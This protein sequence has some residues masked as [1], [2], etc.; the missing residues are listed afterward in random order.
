[1]KINVISDLHGESLYREYKDRDTLYARFRTGFDFSKLEKC[2]ILVIA[3]DFG[4]IEKDF[5]A[6]MQ[7]A[8]K[9]K[10]RIYKELVYVKGNHDFYSDVPQKDSVFLDNNLNVLSNSWNTVKKINNV[11]FVCTPLWSEILDERDTCYYCMNDYVY[12]PKFNID[13]NNDLFY[14]NVEFLKN[15]INLIE[16]RD[17]GDIVIVTHHVPHKKLIDKHFINS[18]LNEAFTV[19]HKNTK[20]S[21]IIKNKKNRIKLWIH[22]HT[23]SFLIKEMNGITFVRNPIGYTRQYGNECDFK[24]DCVFEI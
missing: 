8:L 7:E 12:I 13:T 17:D 4:Y 15:T 24:Y 1:M 5:E 9:W 22:G 10:G 23:H 21:N 19:M 20:L 3:G 18:P 16:E 11:Y 6:V 14:K 2:D